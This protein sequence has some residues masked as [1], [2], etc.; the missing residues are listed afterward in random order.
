MFRTTIG[1]T[2]VRPVE[3]IVHCGIKEEWGDMISL[4]NTKRWRKLPT[5]PCPARG[6]LVESFQD[7][8][9]LLG[10]SIFRYTGPQG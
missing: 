1:N 8:N 10:H 3:Q 9:V 4:P 6:L 7:E 5:H 2:V